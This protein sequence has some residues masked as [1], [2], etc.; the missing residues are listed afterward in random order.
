MNS[1]TLQY[2]DGTTTYV[3][4]KSKDLE[5]VVFSTKSSLNNLDQWANENNLAANVIKTKC[6]LFSTKRMSILHQLPEKNLNVTLSNKTLERVSETKLLGVHLGEHL[7]WNKH[8]KTVAS[9]CH[10]ASSTLRKLKNFTTF[11][12]RKQLAE[13]LVLL[14]VNFNDFV[15]HR[16]TKEQTKK[17]QRVHLA[18][19]SFVY[20]KYVNIE[21]IINL[22]W[23]PIEE[24]RTFSLLKLIHKSMNNVSFPAIIKKYLTITETTKCR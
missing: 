8:I 17:L 1:N 4:A 18:A 12:L 15:C 7:T 14:K 3:S 10:Y 6:M 19:A 5:L 23:L 9:S 24:Q 21:D 13:S 22:K 16:I 2:A 20:N 11:K